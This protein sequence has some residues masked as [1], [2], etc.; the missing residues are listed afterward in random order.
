MNSDNNIG[1]GSHI[2][3]I[4]PLSKTRY[5]LWVCHVNFICKGLLEHWETRLSE[6]YKMKMYCLKWDLN[7]VHSAHEANT[8]TIAVRDLSSFEPKQ[9]K[10]SIT[11][12]SQLDIIVMGNITGAPLSLFCALVTEAW[13]VGQGHK[14]QRGINTKCRS[15]QDKK[16]IDAKASK[17]AEK[18]CLE[19][20]YL[21]QI[22]CFTWSIKLWNK[23]FMIY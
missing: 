21:Y 18:C 1:E 22:P 13:N 10:S 14:P 12:Q 3:S 5:W 7:P 15:Y 16:L 23:V 4:E 17:W 19:I 11:I 2:F 6:N 20:V 9:K 8:L